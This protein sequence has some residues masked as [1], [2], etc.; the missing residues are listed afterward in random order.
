MKHA[1]TLQIA[2]GIALG[3]QA[4]AFAGSETPVA[5]PAAPS[6]PGDWCT[7]LKDKPG[8]LYKNEENPYL[9]EFRL[10]GRFHYQ[11]AY[12]DGSD[13]NGS[14]YNETYDEYRRARIGAKARFLQ[15]FGANVSLNM[16]ADDRHSDGDLDWGYS[17]F[18]EA[19]LTFDL[20]K[21]IGQNP[22]DSLLVNYGRQKVAFGQESHT[23]STKLLTVERSAI[24]NK[25]YG[26]IRPTGVSVDAT[27]DD[28]SFTAGLYSTTRDGAD[29]EAFNGWQDSAIYYANVE[30]K[31]NDELTLAGNVIYNDANLA[32]G[33][34]V[35]M[36]YKWATSISAHYDVGQWGVI[37]DL[38][39]GDNGGSGYGHKSNRSGN[40]WG[41]VV[42]PYCWLVKDKLQLVGQYQYQGSSEDEGVRVNSR[43]G[44]ASGTG[45]GT[46]IDVNSGRGDSHNSFYGGLNYYLCGHNAKIQGGIEYQT[47]DTPKGDFDTLTYIIGFRTYF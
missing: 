46:G 21:A 13:V 12:L 47:M 4:P 2:L 3:L 8:T 10:E 19:F 35:I 43:Y 6:N 41:M 44:R 36:D 18:D 42:M 1:N 11:A 25:V 14:G 22:F 26:G 17:S 27:M 33:D 23:S 37:G 34:N 29:N 32:D 45:P 7:W 40:F 30:Y 15:Y 31:M 9:Q 24:A 28:W 16:V 5:K 20:G 38:I 39:Y